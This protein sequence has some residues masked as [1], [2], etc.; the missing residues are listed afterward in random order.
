[1]ARHPLRLQTLLRKS[2]SFP[3]KGSVVALHCTAHLCLLVRSRGRRLC[4]GLWILSLELGFDGA[5]MTNESASQSDCL[6]L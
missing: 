5:A 4:E 3:R 2:S 6:M 1:M